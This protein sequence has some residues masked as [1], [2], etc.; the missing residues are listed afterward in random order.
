MSAKIGTL[1]APRV[2]GRGD[3][4]PQ[5]RLPRFRNRL[6]ARIA[7]IGIASDAP[8][9][10]PRGTPSARDVLGARLAA[11]RGATFSESPARLAG[12]LT[13]A[14]KLP[15]GRQYAIVTDDESKRLWVVPANK[16][17]RLLEGQQV[18]SWRTPGG[19]SCS[20]ARRAEP[21]TWP[22]PLS[23][24]N[25]SRR[26]PSGCQLPTMSKRAVVFSFA[27]PGCAGVDLWYR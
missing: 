5:E 22:R 13:L 12:T 11:E 16:Q 8:P 10:R 20:H 17:L 25:S 26:R 19:G 7:R 6:L 1:S 4:V 15:S 23:R 9:T 27:A 14:P 2:G 24:R 18:R 3:E 21:D